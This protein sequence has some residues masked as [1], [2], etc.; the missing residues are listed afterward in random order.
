MFTVIIFWQEKEIK[1]E[2][3]WILKNYNKEVEVLF[4]EKADSSSIENLI[5]NIFRIVNARE[6]WRIFL[7]DNYNYQCVRCSN[8]LLADKCYCCEEYKKKNP[9]QRNSRGCSKIYCG[10]GRNP[11]ADLKNIAG[12]LIQEH[13]EELIR[14]LNALVNNRGTE[15]AIPKDIFV[16]AVRDGEF[17]CKQRD[18]I[19]NF[20]AKYWEIDEYLPKQ[21]RYIVYDIKQLRKQILKKEQFWFYC[22]LS[23]LAFSELRTEQF[24]ESMMYRLDIDYKELDYCI[25]LYRLKEKVRKEIDKLNMERAQ[26]EAEKRKNPSSLLDYFANLKSKKVDLPLNINEV[27]KHKN[28]IQLR[29]DIDAKIKEIFKLDLEEYKRE[30]EELIE[31]VSLENGENSQLYEE[32]KV[33]YEKALLRND[34][35]KDIETVDCEG[36]PVNIKNIIDNLENLWK[37]YEQYCKNRPKVIHCIIGILGLVILPIFIEFLY[38]ER[39]TIH[40][41]MQNEQICIMYI[42][43]AVLTLGIYWGIDY[44]GGKRLTIREISDS[45]YK[46]EKYQNSLKGKREK[47]LNCTRDTM[48][49]WK[50]KH[51]YEKRKEELKNIKQKIDKEIDE[52]EL[53][54]CELESLWQMAEET[55][56]QLRIDEKRLEERKEI[57][58]GG[59]KCKTEYIF[60][61]YIRFLKNE[62]ERGK[63]G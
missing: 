4:L 35:S 26:C 38:D 55:T 45:I 62:E 5:Q 6:Q 16:F 22:M 14:I 8:D 24:K 39:L 19:P 50:R 46:L 42:L 47:F 20:T 34:F 52:L 57:D 41:V 31:Q 49:Y 21:C 32:Q 13:R 17:I 29:S 40:N 54:E 7:I 37:K 2:Y 27:L 15:Y 28:S 1:K 30:W 25:F 59:I 63:N 56:G 43:I 12:V 48:F 44:W 51:N 11:F 53:V 58:V 60:I 33:K 36:G 61:K 10:M 3:E 18:S 23:L 9:P